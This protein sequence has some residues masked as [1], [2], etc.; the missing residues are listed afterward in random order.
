MK[1][2]PSLA[3]ALAIA[4]AT[5]LTTPAA[6]QDSAAKAQADTPASKKAPDVLARETA[7]ALLA[8]LKANRESFE[9]DPAKLYAAVE[10]IVL[11]HFDFKYVSQLVLA[12]YWSKA[13]D[14]QRA[15]FMDAF[16]TQLVGFYG[17]ALLDY[18]NEKVEWESADIPADAE[19]AM[20]RSR[21]I[22]SG[23][24]PIPLT[25]SMRKKSDG[26]KVY[27]VTVEGVSL[28]TNY[29]GQFA[30]EIRRNGLDALIARLEKE[31]L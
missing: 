20:V 9:N 3:L 14:D 10:R 11:P 21:I 2:I 15:R 16:K 24:S 1:L 4:P 30:A 28:V 22:P 31:K 17:N 7:D 19:E 12:R 18:S 29:R 6:A 13:S 25:Y 27:D 23:G 5:L 8:E 26:W